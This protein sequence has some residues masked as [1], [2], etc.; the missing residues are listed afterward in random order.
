MVCGSCG[1]HVPNEG[2]KSLT[3]R[4]VKDPYRFIQGSPA[5]RAVYLGLLIRFV[6]HLAAKLFTP[7]K[8]DK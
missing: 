6:D 5:L 2:T 3:V 4:V 8:T 1:I 7:D